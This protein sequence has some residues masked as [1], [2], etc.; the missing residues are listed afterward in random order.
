MPRPPKKPTQQDLQEIESMAGIGLT[1]KQIAS[2]KNISVD[3]L[4][5]YSNPNYKRGKDKGIARVMQTAYELAVSGKCP[6]MTMFFLKTQAGWTEFPMPKHL[7]Q[8]FGEE[9][10]EE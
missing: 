2:I 4:R 3:T 6:A 10:E 7:L 8:M 5:K 1:Q 9:D